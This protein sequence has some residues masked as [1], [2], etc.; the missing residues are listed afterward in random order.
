MRWAGHAERS[1]R[2]WLPLR[3]RHGVACVSDSGTDLEFMVAS[4]GPRAEFAD[5]VTHVGLDVMYVAE[6]DVALVVDGVDYP[7]GERE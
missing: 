2:Q 5:P 1:N 7:V 4:F 3:P 6:G